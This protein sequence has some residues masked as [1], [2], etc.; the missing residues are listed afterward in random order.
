MPNTDR[1]HVNPLSAPDVPEHSV[2]ATLKSL[3]GD[4][5]LDRFLAEFY[6]RQ[7]VHRHSRGQPQRF[8][9]LIDWQVLERLLNMTGCWDEARLRLVADGRR[10]PPE[11]YCFALNGTDGEPRAWRPQPERVMG[12]LNAGATMVLNGLDGLVPAIGSLAHDLEKALNVRVQSNLYWSRRG[13]RGLPLHYDIHDVL[14]LQISGTKRWRWYAH[15]AHPG[16]K[17]PPE[18]ELRAQAGAVEREIALEAGD[19]LYLP[20]G[21]IHEA[22]AQG[23]QSLHLTLGLKQITSMDVASLVM[24]HLSIQPDMSAPRYD[25]HEGTPAL[26]QHIADLAAQCARLGNDP[27]ALAALIAR[28]DANRQPRGRYVLG[29]DRPTGQDDNPA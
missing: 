22:M 21:V 26:A 2:Q 17:A 12:A 10:L 15:R 18:R 24:Q 14:A 13:Q 23:D 11:H 27:E 3:L 25:L 29:P 8:Q 6:G 7:P 4:L 28:I 9:S 16:G 5:K 20:A 1:S 19:L